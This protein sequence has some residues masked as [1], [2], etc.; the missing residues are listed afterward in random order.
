[1]FPIRQTS[2]LASI[3]LRT[4]MGMWARVQLLHP[5]GT[6]TLQANEGAPHFAGIFAGWLRNAPVYHSAFTEKTRKL[7]KCQADCCIVG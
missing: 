5:V 4:C 2:V 3:A 7:M 6:V 1:M